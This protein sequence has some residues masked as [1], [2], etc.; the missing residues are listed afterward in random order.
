MKRAMAGIQGDNLRDRL[1]S[2]GLEIVAADFRLSDR[3][4]RTGGFT[5]F[6]RRAG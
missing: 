4:A 3:A 2:A 1:G 5:A 6:L